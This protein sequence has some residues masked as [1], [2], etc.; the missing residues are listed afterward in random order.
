MGKGPRLMAFQ[1]VDDGIGMLRCGLG[2]GLS[3]C[4]ACV[5]NSGGHTEAHEA[6]LN[7]TVMRPRR[8]ARKAAGSTM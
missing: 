6:L 2:S 1:R 3:P 4:P 8:A 7:A 5:Q